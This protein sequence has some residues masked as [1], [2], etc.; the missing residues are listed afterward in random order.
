M[1][2]NSFITY[3]FDKHYL[4]VLL[5]MLY[6][7]LIY[8]LFF[9][10]FFISFSFTSSSSEK[11]I[12]KIKAIIQMLDP[13]KITVVQINKKRI[14]SNIILFLNNNLKNIHIIIFIIPTKK[15]ITT[16]IINCIFANLVENIVFIIIVDFEIEANKPSITPKKPVNIDDKFSMSSI[17]S[18]IFRGVSQLFKNILRINE[19]IIKPKYNIENNN[20]LI[21]IYTSTP[22]SLSFH[23]LRPSHEIQSL[24]LVFVFHHIEN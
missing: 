14:Q 24:D 9:K 3:C 5:K 8:L 17:N 6:K 4:S 23:S 10:G 11:Y 20:L 22:Y 13:M 1:E 21:F 16:E 15:G 12:I 18:S 7:F 19:I 2:V